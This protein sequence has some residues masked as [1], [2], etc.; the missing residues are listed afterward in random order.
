M[1]SA[2]FVWKHDCGYTIRWDGYHDTA[3]T[4]VDSNNES[5]VVS[6]FDPLTYNEGG[7]RVGTLTW[8][9]HVT[10]QHLQKMDSI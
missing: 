3:A 2:E 8:F 10:H 7:H 5:D 9:E 4:V 6:S 1:S